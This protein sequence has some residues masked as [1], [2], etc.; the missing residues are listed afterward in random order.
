M[1]QTIFFCSLLDI[2]CRLDLSY[3]S[4][5]FI[6]Y[7]SAISYR[8][9]DILVFEE[10]S[11]SGEIGLFHGKFQVFFNGL[12]CCSAAASLHPPICHK[13]CFTKLFTPILI[14]FFPGTLLS[15]HKKIS[16]NVLM[17]KSQIRSVTYLHTYLH[18]LVDFASINSAGF[19]DYYTQ[20]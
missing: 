18:Y 15:Q 12:I 13:F 17:V 16:S 7:S 2:F 8:I 1:F 11:R 4:A 5:I 20:W 6:I 19:S 9:D 14:S 10:G 3:K